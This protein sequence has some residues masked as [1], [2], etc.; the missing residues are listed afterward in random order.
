MNIESFQTIT[1][2]Y[3]DGGDKYKVIICESPDNNG[4]VEIIAGGEKVVFP[5]ELVDA[6]VRSLAKFN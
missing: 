4:Y 3:E 1:I 6:I 2:N 5:K